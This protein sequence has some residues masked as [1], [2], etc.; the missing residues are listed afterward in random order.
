MDLNLREMRIQC[1]FYFLLRL[2]TLYWSLSVQ[3]IFEVNQVSEA[4]RRVR[5]KIRTFSIQPED[6][7]AL[8]VKRPDPT[9][10]TTN[11]LKGNLHEF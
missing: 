5:F 8:L 6:Q 1:E 11:P 4:V 3:H 2:V 10:H 9:L 7:M